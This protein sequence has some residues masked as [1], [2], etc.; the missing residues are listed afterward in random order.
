[1]FWLDFYQIAYSDKPIVFLSIYRFL[2][3]VALEQNRTVSQES[4]LIFY[5][6]NENISELKV[7][8]YVNTMCTTCITVD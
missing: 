8:R 3:T 7:N 6:P 1:M 5:I 2:F 4:F